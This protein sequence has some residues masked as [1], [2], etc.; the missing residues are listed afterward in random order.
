[1]GI[2]RSPN[3][4]RVTSLEA[5]H[6]TTAVAENAIDIENLGDL[7]TPM[8]VISDV[9]VYSDEN[10]SWDIAFFRESTFQANTEAVNDGG[11]DYTVSDQLTL[12]GGVFSTATVLNVDAES[13]GAITAASVVTV[14]EYVLVPTDPVSV[15]GGT[16]TGALF[17]MTWSSSQPDFTL[18]ED[19]SLVDLVSFVDTEGARIAGAGPFIYSR[20]NLGIRFFTERGQALIGLIP[21]TAGG[22]AADPT[23]NVRIEI[24]G[25]VL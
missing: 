5:S 25:P 14:G 24:S 6:Y 13:S 21:R 3:T 16:G 19:H 8:V 11:A 18:L 9:A 17:D 23:G 7:P 1:M 22:K 12:V 15:T 10:L 2:G 4:W 20:S